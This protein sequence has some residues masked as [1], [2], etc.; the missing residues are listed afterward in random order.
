MSTLHRSI[1]QITV[2]FL[3][4][5]FL[6]PMIAGQQAVSSISK[7]TVTDITVTMVD[8]ATGQSFATTGQ[9]FQSASGSESNI[10]VGLAGG[11]VI[12]GVQYTTPGFA[13]VTNG[14]IGSGSVTSYFTAPTSAYTGPLQITVYYTA[15]TRAVPQ[16]VVLFPTLCGIIGAIRALIGIVTLALLLLAAVLLIL[17]A[18][19]HGDYQNSLR[20]WAG[21]MAF[22][23]LVGIIVV[24]IAPALIGIVS[25]PIAPL[26]LPC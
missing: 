22:G 9:G 26:A 23:G 10:G 11:S 13:G 14:G 2:F 8:T 16:A 7:V 1:Y 17:S 19:L 4:A 6:A 25:F 5:S 12:T 21:D 20:R 24:L 18:V 15:G 3:L